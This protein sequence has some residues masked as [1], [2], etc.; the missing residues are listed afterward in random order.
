MNT[1]VKPKSA[2]TTASENVR[3]MAESG[4]EQTRQ[5]FDK[6]SAASKDAAEFMRDCCSAAVKGLQDYNSKVAQF[7]QDNT[8]AHMEFLQKLASV[9]T[10]AE[11]I[12]CSSDHAM[13][14]L[15][16]VNEQTKR[17]TELAQEVTL[18]TAEPLK[19]GFSKAFDR[20]A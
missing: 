9:K 16:K 4:A 20:A 8:K 5:E 6:I 12:G 13:R 15:E 11:F 3:D 2:T 10:P 19:T 18:A 17:L 14:Q 7:A 1:N